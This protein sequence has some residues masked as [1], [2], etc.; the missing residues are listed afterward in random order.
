MSVYIKYFSLKIAVIVNLSS[1]LS[2]GINSD[3]AGFGR[4]LSETKIH[5]EN[6]RFD[7]LKKNTRKYIFYLAEVEENL[8]YK[9]I[10]NSE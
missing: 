10:V 5:I 6:K 9:Y 1:R 8:C 7:K 3:T 4:S 2:H